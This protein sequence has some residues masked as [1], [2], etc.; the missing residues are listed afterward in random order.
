MLEKIYFVQP[1][2]QRKKITQTNKRSAS[3]ILRCKRN[4]A[5]SN[6]KKKSTQ[7]ITGEGTNC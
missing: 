2:H 6:N 7:P 4:V 3:A 5:Q 1:N